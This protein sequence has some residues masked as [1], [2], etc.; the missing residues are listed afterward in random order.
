V[1]INHRSG[2][3]PFFAWG[4]QWLIGME[5]LINSDSLNTMKIATRIVLSISLS[6][7]VFLNAQSNFGSTEE[8]IE[9]CKQHISIYR[10]FLTQKLYREALETWEIADKLCPHAVS[11]HYPNGRKIILGLL[12]IE[13][14]TKI[15]KSLI[16]KLKILY[17][18][19]IIISDSPDET[20][21]LRDSDFNRINK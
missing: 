8:E 2:Q 1:E 7:P 19:W 12:E 6:I 14:K 18:N 13:D 15:K 10:E 21:K 20:I 16:Q 3:F 9:K 11:N 17:D 4:F 5:W